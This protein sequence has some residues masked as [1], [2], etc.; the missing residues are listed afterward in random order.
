MMCGACPARG[1]CTRSSTVGCGYW[2]VRVRGPRHTSYQVPTLDGTA[3]VRAAA[4]HARAATSTPDV[5]SVCPPA[6][7][8]GGEAAA[9][10]RSQ[11]RPSA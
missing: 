3:R 5:A 8:A 2:L 11:L 10:E 9:F 4:R 1:G 7:I 6:T